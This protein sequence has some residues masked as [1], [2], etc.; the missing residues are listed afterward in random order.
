MEMPMYDKEFTSDP[1]HLLFAFLRIFAFTGIPLFL[2]FYPL[3]I[4]NPNAVLLWFLFAAAVILAEI[5]LVIFFLKITV[6]ITDTELQFFRHGKMYESKILQYYRFSSSTH[7]Y[8]YNWIPVFTTRKLRAIAADGTEQNIQCHCFSK[9]TFDLLMTSILNSTDRSKDILEEPAH[10]ESFPAETETLFE[11]RYTFAKDE[12]ISGK[13]HSALF[14]DLILFAIFSGVAVWVLIE[15]RGMPIRFLPFSIVMCA[16]IAPMIH[17]VIFHQWLMRHVPSTILFTGN[18][19]KIDDTFYLLSDIT[20]MKATPV[21]YECQTHPKDRKITI[22]EGSKKTVYVLGSINLGM[23]RGYIY[24]E[25]KD[26][27]GSLKQFRKRSG[28]D[29]IYDS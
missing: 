4:A 13:M 21:N 10:V 9:N 19:L 5:F 11:K 14:I 24:P 28:Q 2:L 3:T 6:R 22:Y 26:L 23:T 12:F 16:A 29:L 1:S 20:G 18:A 15:L 27:V 25:Y 8:R 17:T 7:T